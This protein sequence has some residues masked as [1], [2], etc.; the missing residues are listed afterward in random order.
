[1]R[2]RSLGVIYG[3]RTQKIEKNKM[4]YLFMKNILFSIKVMSFNNIVIGQFF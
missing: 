2:Q 4:K 3:W 1:V